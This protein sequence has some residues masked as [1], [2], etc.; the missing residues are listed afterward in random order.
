MIDTLR[1]DL[2][3]ALRSL[4]RR[5]TFAT[6]AV[7]TLALG[8]GATTAIFS[9]VNGVLLRPLPYQRPAEVMMVHTQLDGMPGKELSPP[10]YWDL[11]ER[12]RSFSRLAAFS[13]GT[14][15]LTGERH[16]RAL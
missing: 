4:R 14:L 7:A 1:H 11:R 8:I 6:L 16:S 13:N 10:E 15:T 2:G 12:N 9:V 5:P 3:Q